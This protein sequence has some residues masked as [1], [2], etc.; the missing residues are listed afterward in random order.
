[1]C[2]I[3]LLGTFML[4][5]SGNKLSLKT[6]VNPYAYLFDFNLQAEEKKNV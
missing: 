2:L 6:D 3:A 1:M 5:L 4:L